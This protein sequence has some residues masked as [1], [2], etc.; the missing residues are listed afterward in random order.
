MLELHQ[1][2]YNFSLELQAKV[3][4]ERFK[5]NPVVGLWVQ[6]D[7]FSCQRH[8]E[9][10]LTEARL[11]LSPGIPLQILSQV[12]ICRYQLVMGPVQQQQQAEIQ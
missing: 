1:V 6:E 9:M 10:S 2:I 5:L 11:P 8:R 4:L 12:D 3:H 7:P